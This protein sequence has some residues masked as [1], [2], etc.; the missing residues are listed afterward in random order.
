MEGFIYFALG[1]IFSVPAGLLVY[2]LGPKLDRYIQ[3]RDL[4]KNNKLIK[5]RKKEIESRWQAANKLNQ[6]SIER[7]VIVMMSYYF[8]SLFLI[9]L[10]AAFFAVVA[11]LNQYFPISID[12]FLRPSSAG[13]FSLIAAGTLFIG[14]FALFLGFATAVKSTSM[15]RDYISFD[16]ITAERDKLIAQDLE[17]VS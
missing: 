15:A 16:N 4:S 8:T 9:A 10:S 14:A 12:A 5:S 13:G 2:R 1:L 7:R 17:S 3:S 11:V 6:L